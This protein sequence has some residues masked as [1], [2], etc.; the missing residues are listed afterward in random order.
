MNDFNFFF[1]KQISDALD[2]KYRVYL[3]GN[4]SRPQ[5]ELECINDSNIEIGTSYYKEFTSDKPH[6]HSRITEY[7]YVLQGKVKLLLIAD[8]REYEFDKDSLFII[9]PNTEYV[10]KNQA[11]TRLL[12][13]K[14]PGGNDKSLVEVDD[15]VLAWMQSWD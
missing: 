5:R 8:N 6:V 7:N 13:I 15:R 11:D 10:S 12:F 3:C 2:K 1:G 9:P 4:L 14:S